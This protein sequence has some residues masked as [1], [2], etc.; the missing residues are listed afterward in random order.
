MILYYDLYR[1]SSHVNDLPAIH[2]L[3]VLIVCNDDYKQMSAF[4]HFS[5]W[6]WYLYT[7]T[8][9]RWSIRSYPLSVLCTRAW[10][11]KFLI[12][13][14]PAYNSRSCCHVL[15]KAPSEQTEVWMRRVSNIFLRWNFAVDNKCRLLLISSFAYVCA[16]D[17]RLFKKSDIPISAAPPLGNTLLLF[18]W[19]A[20]TS[21]FCGPSTMNWWFIKCAAEGLSW[22]NT[23]RHDRMN[24][25]KFTS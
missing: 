12:T 11:N 3:L 1:I 18:V 24:P 14:Q 10:I 21:F 19:A 13:V 17:S 23:V 9:I 8:S 7:F 5:I 22:G 2:C 25:F 15:L 6:S 4:I 20:T 16:S